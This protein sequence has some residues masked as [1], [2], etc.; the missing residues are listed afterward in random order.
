[1]QLAQEKASRSMLVSCVIVVEGIQC[2]CF[3]SFFYKK[4]SENGY[5]SVSRWTKKVDLFSKSIVIV[6]VN[7]HNVVVGVLMLV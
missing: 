2:H 5:A 3:N 4:L 7:L 1:M 6:P